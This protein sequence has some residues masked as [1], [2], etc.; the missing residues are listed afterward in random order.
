MVVP[1]PEVNITNQV[2]SSG[3][4][5]WAV[6]VATLVAALI[7]AAVVMWNEGR[8]RRRED[9]RQWDAEIREW[10]L[11]I[12]DAAQELDHFLFRLRTSVHTPKFVPKK[13]PWSKWGLMSKLPPPESVAGLGVSPE[14][15]Y[16]MRNYDAGAAIMNRLDGFHTR[17]RLIAQPNTIRAFGRL[18]R[19]M[20]DAINELHDGII[21]KPWVEI[22]AK[23]EEFMKAVQVDIKSR[24]GFRTWRR[25][26]LLKLLRRWNR[27]K[28]EWWWK[29]KREVRLDMFRLAVAL[30]LREITKAKG[31]LSC[32]P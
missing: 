28:R 27:F 2:P 11:E 7:T 12:L 17:L 3:V 15:V 32:D 19:V 22:A 21:N 4:P 1:P 25:A 13:Y 29:V 5:G 9:R 16:L 31:D 30:H 18:E 14:N 20:Q 24:G 23:R 6:P 10:T 26:M 8:K